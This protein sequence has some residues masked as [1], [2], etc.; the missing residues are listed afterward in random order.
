MPTEIALVTGGIKG[1]GREIV[2]QF[3]AR[4]VHVVTNYRK[5]KEAAEAFQRE[6]GNAK[7]PIHVF[8]ADMGDAQAVHGLFDFIKTQYGHLDYFVANAAATAFKPLLEIKPHHIDKT[9]A[10]TVTGFLISCQRSA[11]LMN[12]RNGKIVA[13]SGYDTHTYLPR[14][15]V[16]GAAKAAMETLVKYFA[17]ELAPLCINVNAVNPGFLAT[18]STQIYMGP[19]YDEIK[20]IN[21]AITPRH[22]VTNGKEIADVVMFLCSDQANWICGQTI[23]ADGGL[24]HVQP[25]ANPAT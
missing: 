19:A 17:I 16:L 4:G 12:G 14:H 22:R 1:T 24:S 3:I 5:D 23:R 25:I 8:E 10:I 20:R 6:T 13:I 15:G 7:V 21:E 18:T 11:D 9:F 2:K